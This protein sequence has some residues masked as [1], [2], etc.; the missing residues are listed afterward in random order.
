M[1]TQDVDSSKLNLFTPNTLRNPFE[2]R[3][4]WKFFA[5]KS[6]QK[7]LVPFF[8]FFFNGHNFL[9]RFSFILVHT[10]LKKSEKS[11]FF[12]K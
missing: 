12:E 7:E 3:K 11:N 6:Q 9:T 2:L 4:C 1:T 10:S 8:E 5:K